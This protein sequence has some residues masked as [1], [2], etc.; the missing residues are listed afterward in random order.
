M[1]K[2]ELDFGAFGTVYYD[3]RRPGARLDAVRPGAAFPRA[4]EL[5]RAAVR[6]AM[7]V[8]CAYLVDRV[9]PWVLQSLSW[10]RSAKRVTAARGALEAFSFRYA[11]RRVELPAPSRCTRPCFRSRF[12]ADLGCDVMRASGRVGLVEAGARRPAN[13]GRGP[14][15]EG[16]ARRQG[17]LRPPRTGP[18]AAAT[19]GSS[20]RAG[21]TFDC[22]L[23]RG[24][25][26]LL[27]PRDTSVCQNTSLTR[28]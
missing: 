7:L 8:T 4:Q 19:V 11:G 3:G 9:E 26:T 24:F 18:G 10:P 22:P 27:T 12:L 6:R 25:D 13:G 2:V 21:R 5:P 1:E 23:S 28:V 14:A 15:R 17:R 20:L 16:A